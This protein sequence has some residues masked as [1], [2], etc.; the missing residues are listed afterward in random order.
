MTSVKDEKWV[1]EEFNT[2][3]AKSSFNQRAFSNGVNP[4]QAI[5]LGTIINERRSGD[6]VSA[7]LANN[8]YNQ[9][10]LIQE[11]QKDYLKSIKSSTLSIEDRDDSTFDEH[12]PTKSA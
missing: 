11:K 3:Q 2:P 4:I 5:R 10:P 8:Y 1:S 9:L 7:G 6:K 12:S